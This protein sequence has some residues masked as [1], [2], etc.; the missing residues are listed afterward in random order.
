[1]KLI[2]IFCLTNPEMPLETVFLLDRVQKGREISKEAADYLRK[3]KMIEGRYPR[4]YPSAEA[5]KVTNEE[6]KYIRNKAFDDQYYKDLIIQY[7]RTYQKA[8]KAKI[9]E[10]LWDKLPEIL[11]DSQK[12][13][14]I[15][16]LLTS[17][18]EAGLIVT[19]SPN[20]QKC[21]WVLK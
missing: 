14:K 5:S 1:M 10:L 19:D 3:Q 17:M 4:I 13:R 9:R 2:C 11:S 20:Q 8:N 16:Y 7:I 21:S 6:T 12:N 18:R 15:N